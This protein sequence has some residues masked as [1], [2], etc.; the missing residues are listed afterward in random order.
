M[1]L[2]HSK[3]IAFVN[4]KGGCGKTS[5]CV[6]VAAA[7]SALGFSCTVVDTDQQC[8]ATDS[9]GLDRDKHAEA[10]G[11]T[12]ADAFLA[13]KPLRDIE[14]TVDVSSDSSAATARPAIVP[15]NRGLGTVEKRL[16]AELHTLLAEGNQSPLD[17][18]DIRNEHRNRLKSAVASLR[19]RR[20]FILID[21]PPELGFL[22]TTALIAAD[23]YI[24]PVFPSGYDLAGLEQ[25]TLT[26][27][28][29]RKRYNPKLQLLGVLLGNFNPNAKL[30]RDIFQMLQDKFGQDF[31]FSTPINSS[32]RHREATVYRKTI[33]EHAPGQQP[34]EQYLQ[35]ARE[36][37]ARVDIPAQTRPQLEV[38]I[39]SDVVGAKEAVSP[40][41]QGV[42]NG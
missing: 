3:C 22:L 38:H 21:T 13:R 19:G 12:L 41:G 28:K 6:S 31:V 17:A 40:E 11:F 8:N 33:L 15:G 24:V 9:L 4:Q 39:N 5:S 30:D 18:D 23:Y 42:A 35:V 36:I 29:V 16:E 27:E 37:V 26:V 1:K 20:D 7:L 34:S 25:L 32:V 14:V 10:G 2:S